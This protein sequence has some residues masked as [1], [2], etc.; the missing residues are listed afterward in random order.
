MYKGAQVEDLAQVQQGQE[1]L[2]SGERRWRR[3]CRWSLRHTA[4]TA[5][6]GWLLPD[7]RGGRMVV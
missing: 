6:E 1:W 5:R 2:L 3:M 7:V 4:I